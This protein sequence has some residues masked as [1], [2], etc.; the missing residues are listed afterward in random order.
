MLKALAAAAMIVIAVSALGCGGDWRSVG[1]TAVRSR[2]KSIAPPERTVAFVATDGHRS[3]G[4]FVPGR[5][6]G[7]PVVVLFPDTTA[8]PEVWAD[9]VRMFWSAGY[10]TYRW[11][12][13][14]GAAGRELDEAYS[15]RDV[16]GVVRMLRHRRDID[17]RTMAF[18]GPGLGGAIAAYAAG[19]GPDLHIRATVALSPVTGSGFLSLAR[20]GRYHPRRVL[21]ITNHEDFG[22]GSALSPGGQRLRHARARRARRPTRL[23]P[24]RRRPRAPR[25]PGVAQRRTLTPTATAWR[26]GRRG[27]ACRAWR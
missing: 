2:A 3:D 26:R 10:A 22:D 11:P 12:L 8:G 25:H 6:P 17:G 5:T 15:R 19:I 20:R 13:R 1:D 14:H 21:V 23:R 4:V 9:Y 16:D 24:P 7:A 27:Q 18:V